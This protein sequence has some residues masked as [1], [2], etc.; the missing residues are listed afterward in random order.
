MVMEID[1]SV[2]EAY[3][4]EMLERYGWE[5]V[6]SVVMRIMRCGLIV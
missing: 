3:R 2:L 1:C 6:Y 5:D 4:E